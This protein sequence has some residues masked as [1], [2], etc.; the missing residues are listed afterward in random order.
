M[1]IVGICPDCGGETE[2]DSYTREYACGLCSY[3]FDERTLPRKRN[4]FPERIEFA[5]YHPVFEWAELPV[6]EKWHFEAVIRLA[7]PNTTG[8]TTHILESVMV[9][10]DGLLSGNGERTL[11]IDMFTGA[12]RMRYRRLREFRE[13]LEKA[14]AK[15]LDCDPDKIRGLK[16]VV[17]RSTRDQDIDGV[18]FKR[19]TTNE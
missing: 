10:R 5:I 7:P 8:A 18:R 12:K 13:A 1:Q 16:D 6:F 2:R 19:N 17:K 9:S 14:I 4:T 11:S 15:R 3:T